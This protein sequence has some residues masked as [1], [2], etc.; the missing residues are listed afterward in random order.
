MA[1]NPPYRRS[2]PRQQSKSASRLTRTDEFSREGEDLPPDLI[3]SSHKKTKTTPST[4]HL[5]MKTS[6]CLAFQELLLLS[7]SLL[8][9][10]KTRPVERTEMAEEAV[11]PVGSRRRCKSRAASMG[12]ASPRNNRRARRRLEPE[13]REE[14]D[15]GLVE[16][17]GKARKRRQ[18]GR[19]RKEKLSLIP[20]V[21]SPI[22]SPKTNDDDQS[23]L[24]HMGQ[25]I[26]DLIMWKDIA[27][28]SL[29]FGFGSLCFLS[30]CFARGLSFCIFSAV[31][32]LGLLFLGVAFFF[33]S[34]SQRDE[35]D[36]IKDFKLKEDSIVRAARV[37]LPVANLVIVRTRELFSGEPAITLKV[38]PLLLLGAEYGHFITLWRL[39]ATG[40]FVSFTVPK[41]YSCYF[42][43]INRQVEFL[44]CWVWG[45][46]GA[47][48]HKKIVAASAATAF[49]NLSTVKTRIFAAFI[50]MVIFRYYRQNLEVNA[51]E[52]EAEG[53][54]EQKQQLALVVA[55]EITH[56]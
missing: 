19:S 7:P 33:N 44:R 16:E 51:V 24:D 6:N 23:S 11:D 40:F 14:K 31:S 13:P 15:V 42:I 1:S 17:I 55:E 22:S 41:L 54:G 38:A 39:C 43:Q 45:T 30:S 52:G 20:S 4:N 37:M 46:W 10:S 34:F 50:S 27:K 2:E 35:E 48:S 32:Q 28:S 3:H 47:C 21:P 18:S 8:R 36:K 9:R 56:I 5:S 29:W 49:W 53:E 26:S 25:L 12:C